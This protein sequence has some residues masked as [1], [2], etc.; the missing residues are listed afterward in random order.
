MEIDKL[1]QEINCL[2]GIIDILSDRLNGLRTECRT[3]T[4]LTQQEIRTLETKLVKMF[5]RLL[6]VK[7]GRSMSTNAELEQ[8][9]KSIGELQNVFSK[10]HKFTIIFG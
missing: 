8:W 5:A 9:M 3:N 10:I 4:E 2:P 1:Q 7:A 6:I